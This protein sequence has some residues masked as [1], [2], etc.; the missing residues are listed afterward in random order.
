MNDKHLATINLREFKEFVRD[1]YGHD[2]P[3]YQVIVLEMDEMPCEEYAAKFLTWLKLVRM[4]ATTARPEDGR[5][6]S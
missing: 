1:R 3:L 4:S 6:R 2:S 5:H